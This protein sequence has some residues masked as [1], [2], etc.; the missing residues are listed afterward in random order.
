MEKNQIGTDATIHE[1]IETIQNRKYAFKNGNT[2]KPT[3][4]G[5]AI[6]VTYKGLGLPLED[7][8]IRRLIEQR[9]D[10]IAIGELGK[11]PAAL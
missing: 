10:K 5:A 7:C 1:H 4:L 11:D 2:F 6:I 9:M 3:N 8:H